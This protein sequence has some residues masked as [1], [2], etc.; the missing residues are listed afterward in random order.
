M[1]DAPQKRP[2]EDAENPSPKKLASTSQLSNS[3]SQNNSSMQ[4]SGTMSDTM[5]LPDDLVGLII[6]RGG[7]NIMRM[8]RETGC[9]IQITQSIPGTKER[10]CT[11]SGTQEQIEVCKNMLHEIIH[12]SKT[13]TL[14]NNFNL[15]SGLGG[16]GGGMGD[17]GSEKSLEMQIPPDKCGLIIGK[18]GETI[19]M[20]QQ[21][22]GV[23]MLLIQDS[24]ENIGAPK[25]LRI[26]G[27]HVSVDNAVNAVQQMMAQR[28]AQI[29]QQKM[30]RG[31]NNG[32]DS[33]FGDE[34]SRSV[35]AVPKAAVGVVIGKGGDMI[36]QIQNHTGTRIQF[37]PEEPMLAERMCSI[38]GPKD[39]VDHAVRRIHEIIHNVQERDGVM[40]EFSVNANVGRGPPGQAGN[41]GNFG[42]WEGPNM[43]HR[44]GLGGGQICTEEHLVPAN[45]TGLVIG[46]GGETIKQINMQSGAHAEI[47]KNPPPGSADPSYKTFLI[48]G[49]SEQIKLCRQ[50]IQEKVDAGPGGMAPSLQG[51]ALRGP[52]PNAFGPPPQTYGAVP[53][54]QYPGQAQIAPP[55]TQPAPQSFPQTQP[56]G[57]QYQQWTPP[58]TTPQQNGAELGKQPTD[59][60][61]AAYYSYIHLQT[62]AYQQ[63]AATANA[64]PGGVG[65]APDFSKEWNEYLKNAQ[66]A[67]VVPSAAGADRGQLAVAPAAAPAAL[68]TPAASTAGA[69]A[70]PNATQDYSAQWAE[71]YRQYYAIQNQQYAAA[72]AAAAG[73]APTQT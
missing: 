68:Q 12:R 9:R 62:Q 33:M 72:A 7:E 39:G 66:A 30:D 71:Y 14:N 49:T 17:N 13:G 56:W 44:G 47:Q 4:G 59:L 41:L 16:G 6:G 1:G 42:H 3:Y 19:K 46:K 51:G 11:L 67:N 18:G 20:L 26:S 73:Q 10:P 53:P 31:D 27:P 57:N 48:K 50:L 61:N 52:P 55:Q 36:N 70:Q 32:V 35:V 54:T 40:G 38:M 45:K 65:S 22:L 37:K 64:T 63:N 34:L 58:V 15:N 8:Q 24:T 60:N 2:L 43:G 23:K 5:R 28:D 69:T 29:A 21:S 25:P